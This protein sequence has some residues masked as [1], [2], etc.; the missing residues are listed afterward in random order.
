MS[1]QTT[2][3]EAAAATQPPPSLETEVRDL[4]AAVQALV[5]APHYAPFSQPEPVQ[6]DPELRRQIVAVLA[7]TKQDES[8]SWLGK[9]IGWDNMESKTKIATLVFIAGNLWGHG[10]T[11]WN[12]LTPMLGG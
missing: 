11:V 1:E 10:D 8:Q 6:V 4:T 5:A 3:E 12:I 2:K 9:A 7:E